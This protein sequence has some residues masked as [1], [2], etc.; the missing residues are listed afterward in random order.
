[1][2]AIPEVLEHVAKQVDSILL[3]DP[4]SIA[5]FR[6]RAREFCADYQRYFDAREKVDPAE[7]TDEE[8][9][10]ETWPDIDETALKTI[11]RDPMRGGMRGAKY[12]RLP[13]TTKEALSEQYTALAV[14]H[15]FVLREELQESQVILIDKSWACLTVQKLILANKT[16][17]NEKFYQDAVEAVKADL[18]STQPTEASSLIESQVKMETANQ[19]K[20]IPRKLK[21]L[22]VELQ[23]PYNSLLSEQRKL[24]QRCE[25]EAREEKR[26]EVQANQQRLEREALE[27][28]VA[29]ISASGLGS[30]TGSHSAGAQGDETEKLEI[31]EVSE[32]QALLKQIHTDDEIRK[33]ADKK[34]LA[35]VAKYGRRFSQTKQ[36]LQRIAK[37]ID[38]TLTLTVQRILRMYERAKNTLLTADWGRIREGLT[39]NSIMLFSLPSSPDQA[40]D[41]LEFIEADLA[42]EQQDAHKLAAQIISALREWANVNSLEKLP[43]DYRPNHCWEYRFSI[44][45]KLGINPIL[46][47]LELEGKGDAARRIERLRD[48]LNAAITGSNDNFPSDNP[49]HLPGYE[50]GMRADCL[51]ESLKD[52]LPYLGAQPAKG[53]GTNAEQKLTKA[54]GEK[55]TSEILFG[56]QK[57]IEFFRNWW[58]KF[59]QMVERDGEQIE[60]CLNDPSLRVDSKREE[61]LEAKHQKIAANVAILCRHFNEASQKGDH[62]TAKRLEKLLNKKNQE[63]AQIQSQLE[64]PP[65]PGY[66]RYSNF[67][68]QYLNLLLAEFSCWIQ[69]DATLLSSWKFYFGNP[70]TD[71][72]DTERLI[73]GCALLSIFHDETTE[74]SEPKVYRHDDYKGHYFRRDAF[75]ADLAQAFKDANA[76]EK[77]QRA[78]ERVK[79]HLPEEPAKTKPIRTKSKTDGEEQQTQQIKDY[80]EQLLGLLVGEAYPSHMPTGDSWCNAHEA[81]EISDKARMTYWEKVLNLLGDEPFR[82]VRNSFEDIKPQKFSRLEAIRQDILLHTD[83]DKK[84]VNSL[85]AQGNNFGPNKDL[86]SAI[87]R[88][89]DELI[90]EAQQPDVE[91]PTA[92]SGATERLVKMTANNTPEENRQRFLRRIA[93]EVVEIV[94]LGVI[95]VGEDKERVD[96][97]LTLERFREQIGAFN[98]NYTFYLERDKQRQKKRGTL[99]YLPDPTN[100]PEWYTNTEFNNMLLPCYYATLAVIHDT[101]SGK[102]IVKD[103][104]W[105]GFRLPKPLTP[106]VKVTPEQLAYITMAACI[107]KLQGGY[108]EF[109]ITQALSI[110]K[111]DLL[112]NCKQ[113]DVEKPIEDN[114]GNVRERHN[115]RTEKQ[116]GRK[117]LGK[118]ET[119]K[120]QMILSEWKEACS[121]DIS[122]NDFCNDKNIDIK[123]LE[124]CQAWKRQRDARSD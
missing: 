19:N 8:A 37:E 57:H 13:A 84:Q 80:A 88:L 22:L 18:A 45:N 16:C 6:K 108:D 58:N 107:R 119:K 115:K 31:P 62:T 34:Y 96:A 71:L 81:G 94:T 52:A 103:K 77:I 56:I 120:R 14:L 104:I 50:L 118:Q 51:V 117:P 97:K 86:I 85:Q 124:K 12:F 91:K 4:H 38:L 100:W 123:Y 66:V 10:R 67:D 79:T 116:R 113:P 26:K 25:R 7:I 105:E 15:D 106:N 78:W 95:T 17:Y 98:E 90:Q 36:Q 122:R 89:H 61:K 23:P 44:H 53:T 21:D 43:A 76:I 40:I 121:A 46:E 112:K 3:D 59:C 39:V 68:Y 63:A 82:I 93:G 83:P 64:S 32:L 114:G 5:I 111:A 74:R 72:T 35:R 75:A 109:T 28:Q 47:K 48:E 42:A 69:P 87:K 9:D 29:S 54:S 1:M 101:Q 55:D 41:A 11:P 92:A 49:I 102:P 70:R 65:K 73:Y 60:K 110:V 27:K 30:C 33:L 2:A 20:P 24:R 99:K